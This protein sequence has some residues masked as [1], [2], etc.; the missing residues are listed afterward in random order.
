MPFTFF[1]RIRAGLTD[2]ARSLC[3]AFLLAATGPALAE[4]LVGMVVAVQDG[5]TLTV[6]DA[7][8]VQ[9]KI[10]LAGIDAPEKGQPWGQR[11]KEGLSALAYRREVAVE[12]H[13]RD[14]YG[15]LIGKVL[16]E[17]RDVNLT[18]VSSGLAWHYVVREGA[19][20]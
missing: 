1:V 13:K 9:H 17:H 7:E 20:A 18:Q 15:R 8:K 3:V 11:S 5:D 10:R 2:S 12:W 6:L 4:T 16:V 14:R 19:V